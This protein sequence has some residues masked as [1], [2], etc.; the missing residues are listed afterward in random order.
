MSPFCVSPL[1]RSPVLETPWNIGNFAFNFQLASKLKIR[2]S[3]VNIFPV[4]VI[5]LLQFIF[6]GLGIKLHGRNKGKLKSVLGLNFLT[7]DGWAN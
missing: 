7:S 2:V 3:A 6:C 1:L 4:H 5:L